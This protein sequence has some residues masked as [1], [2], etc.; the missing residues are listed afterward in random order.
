MKL[1]PSLNVSDE[2]WF[3]AGSE[4]WVKLFENENSCHIDIQDKGHPVVLIYFHDF[5]FYSVR[6]YTLDLN[7]LRKKLCNI[8]ENAHLYE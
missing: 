6:Y 8:F 3:L 5:G 2:I 4:A 7:R 1:P